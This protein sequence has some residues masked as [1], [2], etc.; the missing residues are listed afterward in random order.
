MQSQRISLR[1]IVLIYETSRMKNHSS[2]NQF[3]SVLISFFFFFLMTLDLKITREEEEENKFIFPSLSAIS[4]DNNYPR[5]EMFRLRHD[6]HSLNAVYGF[7]VLKGRTQP[8]TLTRRKEER[9]RKE[10]NRFLI[11]S[12]NKIPGQMKKFRRRK[13]KRWIASTS[14]FLDR[15]QYSTSR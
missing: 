3:L 11:S 4:S 15:E 2:F 5:R 14:V 12:Y 7:I 13:S 1:V 9:K 8:D 10:A 6:R